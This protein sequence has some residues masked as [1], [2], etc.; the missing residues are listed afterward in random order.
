MHQR[1]EKCPKMSPLISGVGGLNDR[2][3]P[4]SLLVNKSSE[5]VLMVTSRHTCCVNI[6]MT[7]VV[8]WR[9]KN[10]VAIFGG[11]T[12]C[13]FVLENAQ[14]VFFIIIYYI[15]LYIFQLKKL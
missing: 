15:F 1:N 9:P 6:N 14:V 10:T 8:H 4:V 11:L 2:S 12:Y 13:L 7:E 3:R 5:V